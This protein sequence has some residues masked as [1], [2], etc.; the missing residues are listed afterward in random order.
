[1]LVEAW[2]QCKDADVLIESPSAM[3][4]VHIAEAL[5]IYSTADPR[6]PL[7]LVQV[8]HI[9]VLSQCHGPERHNIP[10]HSSVRL[11]RTLHALMS[12]RTP[13]SCRY[14]I[15]PLIM[16]LFHSATFYSTMFSGLAHLDRSIGGERSASACVRQIWD[17]WRRRKSLS[18][19][20]SRRYVF[21]PSLV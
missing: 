4:G 21:S 8:S 7:I 11:S 10:T 3:A 13:I 19:I 18:C 12:H 1:V 9:S 20:I 16:I 14:S 15:L 2:E 6:S 17:I 5:G